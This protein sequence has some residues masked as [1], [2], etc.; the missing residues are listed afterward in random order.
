MSDTM[1]V[2]I[3]IED[4]FVPYQRGDEVIRGEQ[5]VR[6]LA[7]KNTFDGAES[8]DMPDEV[9]DQFKSAINRINTKDAAS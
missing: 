2:T 7:L 3:S 9:W 4:K 1:R 5:R 6:D 8:K